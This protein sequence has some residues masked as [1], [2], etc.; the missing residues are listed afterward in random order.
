MK[1]KK[2]LKIG[3]ITAITLMNTGGLLSRTSVDASAKNIFNLQQPPISTTLPQERLD[4]A[5]IFANLIYGAAF[6]NKINDSSGHMNGGPYPFEKEFNAHLDWYKTVDKETWKIESDVQLKATYLPNIKKSNKT[7][8]LIHGFSSQP[9]FMGAWAKVYYD[10]GYNILTPEMRGHGTSPDKQRS[11][12]WKDKDDIAQ[13]AKL[14]NEKT[15]ADSEI[16]LSG[17]SMGASIAMMSSTATELP[18][19]VKA[20]IEDCGYTSIAEQVKFLINDKLGF[21]NDETRALVYHKLNDL[22]LERQGFKMEE[23]SAIDQI[24]QSKIPLL[25]IH[26]DS[27]TAVPTSMAKAI[28]EA[29]PAPQKDILLVPSASHPEAILFDL[30]QYKQKVASFLEKVW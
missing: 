7:V 15:G 5:G 25:V 17:L 18:Q 3:I 1:K 4:I 2:L 29:S 24:K 14:L 9:N 30:P 21:L 6:T 19:N 16:I 10:L 8:I 26:G 28:Y 11:L 12:G 20:I 13:W 22:L 27:D 23:G